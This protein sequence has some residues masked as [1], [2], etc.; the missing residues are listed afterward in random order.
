[1]ELGGFGLGND[2]DAVL[3]RVLCLNTQTKIVRQFRQQ[4]CTVFSSIRLLLSVVPH[5]HDP[6]HKCHRRP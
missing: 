6:L 2:R 1:M 3:L 4:R 5:I